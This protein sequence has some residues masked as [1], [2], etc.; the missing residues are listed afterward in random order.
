MRKSANRMERQ[1]ASCQLPTS[2]CLLP[3]CGTCCSKGKA[4]EREGETLHLPRPF[5]VYES[6]LSRRLL[7]LLPLLRRHAANEVI[8]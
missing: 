8:H 1:A 3:H 5:S 6:A 7:W 2:N 4:R